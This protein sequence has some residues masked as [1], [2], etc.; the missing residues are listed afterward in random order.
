M[1]YSPVLVE[2][3]LRM[4]LRN[5]RVPHDSV[6]AKRRGGVA[7]PPN[8]MQQCQ[9]WPRRHQYF[10][11]DG[12]ED[13]ESRYCLR[14]ARY[15]FMACPDGPQRSSLDKGTT[16]RKLS[17]NRATTISPKVPLCRV[18][19]KNTSAMRDGQG[20]SSGS[21]TIHRSQSLLTANPR[22]PILAPPRAERVRLENLLADV[23]SRESLPFPGVS[24]R[25]GS[26]HLVRASS[27][28]LKLSMSNLAGSLNKRSSSLSRRTP[29]VSEDGVG[30]PCQRKDSIDPEPDIRPSDLLEDDADTMTALKRPRIQEMA[31][32]PTQD[33]TDDFVTT[34]S[35]ETV[36]RTE[37]RDEPEP[38]ASLDTGQDDSSRAR[39]LRNSSGNSI[40]FTAPKDGGKGIGD[41]LEKE[42]ACEIQRRKSLGRWAKM[43]HVAKGDGK[44]HGLR[45]FFR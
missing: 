20:S 11:H 32:S 38:P 41:V 30:V 9:S 33:D 2:T 36:R 35:P 40:R 15:E 21:L 8:W 17:I 16:A 19:L 43:G 28:M 37:T 3:Y 44:G 27:M 13:E 34:G 7:Q 42:N 45:S 22:L 4:R 6:L 24:S 31:F 14:E 39:M 5:V 29:R 12:A 25:P 18:V 1:S 23:W 10:Q 26:G